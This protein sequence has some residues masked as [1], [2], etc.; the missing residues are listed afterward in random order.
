M[1]V[2]VVVIRVVGGIPAHVIF[3]VG[4][5]V[6]KIP[7]EEEGESPWSSDQRGQRAKEAGLHREN[8]Q[9]IDHN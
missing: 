1:V 3:V 9:S 2:R 6:G 4:V 8:T 7:Q 5:D